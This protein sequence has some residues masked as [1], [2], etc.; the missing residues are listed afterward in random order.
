METQHN[1]TIDQ[2]IA[3]R[4]QRGQNRINDFMRSLKNLNNDFILETI[5]PQEYSYQSGIKYK[6][7][8]FEPVKIEFLTPKQLEDK[9]FKIFQNN[10]CFGKEKTKFKKACRDCRKE[11]EAYEDGKPQFYTYT[12]GSPYCKDKDCFLQR[13]L[14]GKIYFETHFHTRENWKKSNRCMHIVLGFPRMDELPT[15]EQL[16]NMRL[17]AMRFLNDDLSKKLKLYIKGAGILDIAYSEEKGYYFH[18]HIALMKLSINKRVLRSMNEFGFKRGLKI[19]VIGYRKLDSVIDYFSK[20]FA[21]KFQH[22]THSNSWMFA[23]RISQRDFFNIFN[24]SR[25]SF[26]VGFTVKEKK[27]LKWKFKNQIRE[28][29]LLSSNA[30]LTTNDEKCVHCGCREF[31]MVRHI[32]NHVKKPPDFSKDYKLVNIKEIKIV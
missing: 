19:K 6:Q 7:K 27:Y 26:T 32:E 8:H 18:F 25:K 11:F 17:Q 1:L 2:E 3:Y 4:K 22:N 23:E 29:N 10:I 20:R 28:A 9:K 24:R 5:T 16:A 21:G 12:C 15:R 14:A 31:R 30:L 13:K